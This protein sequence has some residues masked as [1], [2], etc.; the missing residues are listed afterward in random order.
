MRLDELFSN[1]GDDGLSVEDGLRQASIDILT[2]LLANK[3]PFVTIQS[4]INSLR[5]MKPGILVDRSVIMDIL[6]P[7]KVK[8]VSKI[9]GDKI[10][11]QAPDDESVNSA[12]D[13]KEDQIDKVKKTAISKAQSDVKA[14]DKPK[15][16]PKPK[17]DKPDLKLPDV[18]PDKKLD[19]K[20]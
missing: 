4:V 12:E 3:V 10:Y 17:L 2:P 11:L 14:D 13:E 16:K 19:I 9:D 8:T 1:S 18:K 20:I 6:D 7:D 5:S 15:A